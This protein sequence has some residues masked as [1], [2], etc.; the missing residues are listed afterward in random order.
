MA[1]HS[2]GH[3]VLHAVDHHQDPEVDARATRVVLHPAAVQARAFDFA[4]GVRHGGSRAEP[5]HAADE[6]SRAEAEPKKTQR[7][8][9]RD[10]IHRPDAS[11]GRRRAA[12]GV[13]QL[14]E[15]RAA[16]RV[17]HRAVAPEPEPAAGG[18]PAQN[19]PQSRAASVWP[20]AA[21]A[22]LGVRRRRHRGVDPA[23]HGEPR[24]ARPETARGDPAAGHGERPGA[25]AGVGRRVQ[26][27]PH[28]RAAAA[29]AGGAPRRA[30]P[31]GGVHHAE[32]P[33]RAAAEPQE[34]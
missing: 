7:R 18:G 9:H 22:H 4:S 1:H 23:D 3:R 25:R 12:V 16:R 20:P 17:P 32:G 13:R 31:L 34:G 27:R 2:R 15:R 14:A 21:R 6:E 11:A 24:G 30:G 5:V 26:Q 19:R 8:V 29:D 10:L 28:L 33:A